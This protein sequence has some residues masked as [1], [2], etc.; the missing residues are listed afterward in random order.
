MN[1]IANVKVHLRAPSGNVNI[2]YE[3]AV[4]GIVTPVLQNALKIQIYQAIGGCYKGI[5][6]LPDSC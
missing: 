5:F 6:F 3:A 4:T 1:D 2:Q